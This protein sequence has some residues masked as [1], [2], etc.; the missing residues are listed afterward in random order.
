MRS[1]DAVVPLG[2][3]AGP[4]ALGFL[5]PSPLPAPGPK[6]ALQ[7]ASLHCPGLLTGRETAGAAA[8]R[9]PW[10]EDASAAGPHEDLAAATYL[11]GRSWQGAPAGL[12]GLRGRT[13]PCALLPDTDHRGP[14]LHRRGWGFLPGTLRCQRDPAEHGLSAKE[15]PGRQRWKEKTRDKER[16]GE[17]ERDGERDRETEREK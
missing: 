9:L 7:T 1:L 12:S 2:P 5:S 4:Q 3:E 6:L 10:P 8:A 15:K 17:T 13:A 14:S 11:Q 16:Q